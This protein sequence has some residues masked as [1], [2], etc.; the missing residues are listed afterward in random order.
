MKTYIVRWA[1][2]GCGDA[3]GSAGG[4][5]MGALDRQTYAGSDDGGDEGKKQ[6][7]HLKVLV[8]HHVRRSLHEDGRVPHPSLVCPRNEDLRVS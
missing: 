2:F 1:L 7:N 8:D 6:K 3:K 5:D 4:A